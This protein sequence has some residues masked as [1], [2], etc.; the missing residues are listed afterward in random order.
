MASAQVVEAFDHRVVDR[1]R[2]RWGNAVVPTTARGDEFEKF[3][4]ATA[5]E[6]APQ[7]RHDGD[8]VARIIDGLQRDQGLAHFLGIEY[9]RA[10]FG[11]IRDVCLAQRLLERR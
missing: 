7:R 9:Q 8:L 11:P 5:E 1:E 6:R 2:R 3:V 4:V 10:R